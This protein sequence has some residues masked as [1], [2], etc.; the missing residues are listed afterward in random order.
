MKVEIYIK[1]P[2][3]STEDKTKVELCVNN[4]LEFLPELSE[5]HENGKTFLLSENIDIEHLKP[6]FLY[7]RRHEIID[8]VRR[9]AYVD[10]LNNEII[11][12]IHKQALTVGKI[13][14]VTRDTTSP[15]GHLE[16]KIRTNNHEKF[17]DWF[18][19]ETID[20]KIQNP[21]KFGAI[22]NL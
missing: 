17:L 4:L 1:I 14:V 12:S 10:S 18:A 15:L 9:Y 2:L 19:P 5:L 7:I 16:L 8:T 21:Q 6:F 13:A 3:F 11:F 22:F 20:G